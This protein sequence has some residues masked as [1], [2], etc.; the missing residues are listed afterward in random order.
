MWFEM[1]QSIKSDYHRKTDGFADKKKIQKNYHNQ[2]H[3]IEMHLC[4][5]G[6]TINSTDGKIQNASIK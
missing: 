4:D 5:E 3:I 1:S 6:K 2:I